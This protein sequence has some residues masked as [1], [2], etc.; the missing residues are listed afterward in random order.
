MEF[1]CI[2]PGLVREA[3][4]RDSGMDIV[5]GIGIILMVLGHSGTRLSRW[6]YLFHMALFFIVAGYCLKEEYSD[7][8]HG[9]IK[10]L[11]KR[12]KSL[13]VPCL[14]FNLFI[15]LCHNSFYRMNLIGGGEYTVKDII[16]G[17][18][19]C[20]L[21]SGGENLSAAMWFLRTMF[22]S[23]VLYAFT[24]LLVKK[25]MRKYVEPVKIAAFIVMLILS[26]ML[27]GI[28]N[29]KYLNC[30]TVLILFETGHLLKKIHFSVKLWYA[31]AGLVILFVFYF[32]TTVSINLTANEINDP[33]SF[34]LC[35][36]CG[37]FMCSYAAVSLQRFHFI[38]VVLIY[39]GKHTLPIVMFHFLCMKLVTLLQIVVYKASRDRL[40]S[41]PYYISSGGWWL[42]YTAVGVI[43]PL[44]LYAV[45]DRAK[46][47]ISGKHGL[48]RSRIK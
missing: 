5:K 40:S 4:K 32:F 20:V 23:T 10:L 26:W 2:T 41:H 34:L 14:L 25:L 37:F 16:T 39:V 38:K 35:S 29:A 27:N 24:D 44:L 1:N 13:Y 19:K 9:F 30:F 18:C 36:L 42:A 21:F 43:L 11:Q 33:V 7:S 28:P 45:F 46:I 22:L 6:I 48:N 8:L 3:T 12:I 31:L 17:I 47:W 15:V